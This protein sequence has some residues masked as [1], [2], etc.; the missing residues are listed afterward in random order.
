MRAVVFIPLCLMGG[1][2]L[3]LESHFH[4]NVWELYA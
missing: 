1:M 2:L 4:R 3:M